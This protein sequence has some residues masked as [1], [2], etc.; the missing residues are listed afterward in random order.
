MAD[1][2]KDAP[3]DLEKPSVTVIV[4]PKPG[5]DRAEDRSNK[6]DSDRIR[7][8]VKKEIKDEITKR[9]GQGHRKQLDV[10]EDVADKVKRVVNPRT[11]EKVD[12]KVDGDDVSRTRKVTP[13]E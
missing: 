8:T 4:T 9:E 12:I 7:E 1:D 10:V 11:V 6:V 13:K 5:K 2:K 3:K